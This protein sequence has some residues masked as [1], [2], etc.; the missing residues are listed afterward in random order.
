MTVFKEY[1]EVTGKAD[2]E[3]AHAFAAARTA[4]WDAQWALVQSLGGDGFRPGHGGGIK[5]LLFKKGAA[6]P[7]GWR[8]TGTDQGRDECVPARN[9]KAGKEIVKQLAALPKVESWARFADTF[10]WNGR[11]P[12]GS[13]GGRGVIYFCTGIHVRKPKDRFFVWYPRELKDGWKA[14][15]GL[16][17]V[18]ESDMLRAVEDHNQAIK[19]PAAKAA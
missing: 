11:S 8:K 18:R 12:M 10:G 4:A 16:T 1:F 5:S 13:D 19:E 2:L 9:T 3:R 7:E 14:P 17:E 6:R 15:E